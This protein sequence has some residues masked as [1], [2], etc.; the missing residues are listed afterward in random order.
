MLYKEPTQFSS[1]LLWEI[2][3]YVPTVLHSNLCNCHYL[4]ISESFPDETW[5]GRQ[6]A[7]CKELRILSLGF[8]LNKQGP[9]KGGT[10][11]HSFS[12]L[13]C[14]K[15]CGD[16]PPPSL[17]PFSATA[18]KL[19]S[20]SICFHSSRENILNH[21]S[22]QVS[23]LFKI[24]EWKNK[25]IAHWVQNAIIRYQGETHPNKNHRPRLSTCNLFWQHSYIHRVLCVSCCHKM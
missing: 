9:G 2:N 22:D 14:Q 24:P 10:L 16:L 25:W 18:I 21:K 1:W 13:H 5:T 19:V 6:F 17:T 7:L 11:S 20:V 8:A 15:Q 3:P 23:P 12:Q 4:F